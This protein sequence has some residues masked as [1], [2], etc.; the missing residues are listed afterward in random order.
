MAEAV[1][2]GLSAEQLYRYD[3]QGFL[4]L[5]GA[6]GEAE[7]AGIR[8]MLDRPPDTRDADT[9][10]ER[11]ADPQ[12]EI[13]AVRAVIERPDLLARLID[14]INQPLRIVECYG[15]RSGVGA[16]LY[17]H[18]G[19]TQDLVYEGGIRATKN[20]AYR[21]E[22]HDGRLYTTFVKLL[23]Y[24]TD[25]GPEDGPF[26]Y[27]AGSH[28]A[29]FAFPWPDEVRRGETLLSESGHP[30]VGTV[31]VRAG[32]AILLNEA[33]LHG[34]CVRHNPG[35]RALLAASYCPAFMADWGYLTR[36]PDDLHSCGYPDLD[37][38]GDF[39]RDNG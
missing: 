8:A 22:Y 15:H 14:V 1:T 39:F 12:R 38:E 32:D 24:L 6:L 26:C 28:K 9:G 29:N 31:P 27:V 37:D 25:V 36:A 21:C 23:V 34:A 7:L 16:F 18:N 2:R 33:L 11:W 19:N 3:A 10:I 5:P 20:M 4:H 30:L 17:L 35:H 13:D